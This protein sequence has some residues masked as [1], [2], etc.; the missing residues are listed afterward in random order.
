MRHDVI[1]MGDSYARMAA[2]LQLLRADVA[3]IGTQVHRS[4][5][6]PE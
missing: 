5:V 6:S 3:M 4:L 1:I 2:A